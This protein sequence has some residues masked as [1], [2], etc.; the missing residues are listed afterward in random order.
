MGLSGGLAF[1]ADGRTLTCASTNELRLWD[2]AGPEPR[3]RT[4]LRGH[5]LNVQSFA[6]S[7]DGKLLASSDKSGVVILRS[8]P[9]GEVVREWRLPGAV[10]CVGFAGDG[11]HL[12]TANA[13]GTAYILRLAL[14]P[15][16]EK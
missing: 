16:A 15:K 1:T 4:I 14:P 5:R 13:V 2:L 6:L 10:Y 8:F 11:R 3:E 7:P 9:S 12:A